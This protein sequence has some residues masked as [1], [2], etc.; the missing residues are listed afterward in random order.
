MQ[1]ELA[2]INTALIN[3]MIIDSDTLMERI[4]G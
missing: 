3:G 4:M 1:H 2:S